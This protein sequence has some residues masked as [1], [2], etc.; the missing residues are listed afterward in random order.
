MLKKYDI[1]SSRVSRIITNSYSTSFSIGISAL[2]KKYRKAIYS[3]YAFVRL[4]DEIVDSFH[5]CD[6]ALL[7][8][9]FEEDTWIAISGRM[10]LNPVLFGFQKTVNKY[11]I[12]K[13]LIETFL[14]SMRM[15][16]DSKSYNRETYNQYILGSA[17]VV[18]LMCLQVFCDGNREE[19][20]RLKVY[21]MS[22]GAAFQK[23]N[24]LRDMK[25]DG[26]ELGR[27]YFPGLELDKFNDEIK[28]QIEQ[29]IEMDFK[30]A[31]TGILMLPSSCRLGV[32]VS[33]LY[34]HALLR[35]IASLKASDLIEA[36]IRI[37]NLRKSVLLL[38]GYFLVKFGLLK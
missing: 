22:L 32:L 11:G 12:E 10:S 6:K 33:Y 7:L 38:K 9:R 1:V 4:A 28:K 24:F 23:I 36:R 13:E 30:N 18:G 5:E 8:K 2:D 20:N 15:D 25:A 19:F 34:Y 31:Y 27:I 37:S 14:A 29:E 35:K 3:I 21:A 17:E 16:L 26:I